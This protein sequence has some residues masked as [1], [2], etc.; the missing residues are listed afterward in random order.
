M[1]FPPKLEGARVYAGLRRY[2]HLSAS[3]QI[4]SDLCASLKVLCNPR[5]VSTRRYL[6]KLIAVC[7]TGAH[8][9]CW[10]LDA[11]FGNVA[12]EIRLLDSIN[13]RDVIVSSDVGTW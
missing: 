12:P 8:S 6:P 4:L 9:T 2:D 10:R 7:A 1:K 11:D 3:C 13:D 5:Y